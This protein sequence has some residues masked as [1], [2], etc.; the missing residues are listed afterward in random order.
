MGERFEAERRLNAAVGAAA[1]A[2]EAEVAERARER[3]APRRAGE[4]KAWALDAVK[5][6]GCET[7]KGAEHEA[8]KR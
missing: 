5:P 6:W 4:A 8:R 1:A 7:K 2:A 3:L